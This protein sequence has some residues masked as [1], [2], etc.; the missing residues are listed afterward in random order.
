MPVINGTTNPENLPGTEGNDTINALAGND[1]AQGNGGNDLIDKYFKGTTYTATWFMG[2]KSAIANAPALSD[3]M[4]SHGAW[5]EI[6]GYTGSTNRPAITFG[7][8]SAKSNTATLIAFAINAT[9]TIG[10][11]FV[12]NTQP[13]SPGN[14]GILYSASNFAADRNAVS[15]DTL[16]VTL[17]VSV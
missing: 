8:T 15:G 5:T 2:L 16:N 1:S 12:S 17:T 9:V 3:T 13:T 6:T 10:G 11:A 4:A 7:T 14:V